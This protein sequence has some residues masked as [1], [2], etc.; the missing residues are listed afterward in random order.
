MFRFVFLGSDILL[1]FAVF[2]LSAF[3]IKGLRKPINKK[4]FKEL[5]T[6]KIVWLTLSV[7]SVYLV[8][9]LLDSTHFQRQLPQGDL[10]TTAQYTAKTESLLDLIFGERATPQEK[11]YSAPFALN[12]YIKEIKHS[13]GQYYP[14][15][16]RINPD[17]HT[18]H[19]RNVFIF[20]KLIT[21]FLYSVLIGIFFLMFRY[22]IYQK[23]SKI[24]Y[25]VFF[26]LMFFS[27][28]NIA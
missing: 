17:I 14:K 11:T 6:F 13:G 24:N 21:A 2:I 7:L 23:A 28:I 9:S 8:I 10:S 19:E 5:L 25:S 18:I 16:K 3:V 1:F 12:A 4:A 26:M 27:F 15:L 20:K 22:F